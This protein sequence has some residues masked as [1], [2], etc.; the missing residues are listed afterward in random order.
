MTHGH[1]LFVFMLGFTSPRARDAQET[2]DLV[3]EPES[4][5]RFVDAMLCNCLLWLFTCRTGDEN[6]FCDEPA[7]QELSTHDSILLEAYHRSFD[8]EKVWI[9]LF[10]DGE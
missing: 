2:V 1:V 4:I 8:D 7:T 9:T 10:V 5:C 6:E 3:F